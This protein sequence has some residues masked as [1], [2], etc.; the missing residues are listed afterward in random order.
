[1]RLVIALLTAGAL[2]LAIVS[3]VAAAPKDPFKGHW[4]AI[5]TDQSHQTLK[6]S[7]HGPT[8]TW[9]FFD[10]YCTLCGGGTFAGSGLF[11]IEGVIATFTG[12]GRSNLT[13]QILDMSFW[14]QDDSA[15]GTLLWEGISDPGWVLYRHHPW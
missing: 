8:R 7:G 5:D 11:T 14:L 4:Y 12:T 9:R 13:G 3:S 10:D 2:T 1:M 15:T 6:L